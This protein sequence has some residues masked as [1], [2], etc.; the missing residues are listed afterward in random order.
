MKT[1]PIDLET[2][3][4]L[5]KELALPPVM[6]MGDMLRVDH[7]RTAISSLWRAFL[8]RMGPGKLSPAEYALYGAGEIRMKDLYQF[9]GVRIQNNL[10]AHCNDESWFAITK[11]K[12]L[13][14]AIM[15]GAGLPAP[16]TIAAYDRKGRGSGPR[17]LSS[18]KELAVFLTDEAP[19]P[20]FCKP[21]TG[22]NSLGAFRMDSVRSGKVTINGRDQRPLREAI[23]FMCEY[24]AKGYLFQKPLLP[25]PVLETTLGVDGLI[26][27]RFFVLLDGGNPEVEV[28]LVKLPGPGETA[29][30]FWRDGALAC[31]VDVESG[32]ILRSVFHDDHHYRLADMHPHSGCQLTGVKLPGYDEALRTVLAAAPLLS[33]IQTQSWD[34]ALTESGPVLLEVNFGGDLKLVQTATG[35][36][37]F[38]DSYCKHLRRCGFSGRLPA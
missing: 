13:F 33:G 16:E 2:T 32:E 11:N 4:R 9:A 20:I 26:S 19:M 25:D 24:S 18:R 6:G 27:I 22:V 35:T 5:R 8:A 28:C 14:E 36:G 15:K 31:S 3:K 38:T 10:H 17:I 7:G 30:N 12:L 23:D 21:V 37:I 29:D 1:D 34:V